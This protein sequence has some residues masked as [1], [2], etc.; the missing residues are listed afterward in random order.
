[1][2]LFEN[3]RCTNLIKKRLHPSRFPKSSTKQRKRDE[4]EAYHH[5]IMGYTSDED[6]KTHQSYNRR[7]MSEWRMFVRGLI[8]D[9]TRNYM[10]NLRRSRAAGTARTTR[11]APIMPLSGMPHVNVSHTALSVH[12]E[13]GIERSARSFT[14]TAQLSRSYCRT[15]LYPPT[16][17][18]LC[19]IM[20]AE[21]E[22]LLLS[23]I[24]FAQ[25]EVGEQRLSSTVFPVQIGRTS[26]GK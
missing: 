24:E 20:R 8:P 5:P 17:S 6:K 3:T 2:R 15:C 13:I 25:T 12:I 22:R 26:L 14:G 10:K 4:K 21:S 1:M 19:I 9:G 7:G 16:N 18:T 11:T 23:S